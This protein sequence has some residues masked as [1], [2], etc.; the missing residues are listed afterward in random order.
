[1]GQS[2]YVE[3]LPVV[4]AWQAKVGGSNPPDLHVRLWTFGA[5]PSRHCGSHISSNPYERLSPQ[6]GLV[7]ALAMLEA[8][9]DMHRASLPKTALDTQFTVL[10]KNSPSSH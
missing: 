3:S 7:R 6:H 8:R 5:Y 2:A 10:G 4:L 1:M 9:G